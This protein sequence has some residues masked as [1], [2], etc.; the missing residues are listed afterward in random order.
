MPVEVLDGHVYAKPNMPTD[1][2]ARVY[3]LAYLNQN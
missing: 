2:K 3:A 1:R